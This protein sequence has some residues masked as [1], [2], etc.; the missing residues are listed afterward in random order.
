MQASRANTLDG[1]LD[2]LPDLSDGYFSYE[3][4]QLFPQYVDMLNTKGIE[5]T[6]M[7]RAP[8]GGSPV[9]T[10]KILRTRFLDTSEKQRF[11]PHRK[12]MPSPDR[13]QRAVAA[14]RQRPRST[15]SSAVQMSGKLRT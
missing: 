14:G 9:S 8:N 1:I 4:D 12:G 5:D 15:S 2:E 11:C 13:Q 3:V 10:S 7:D 6:P